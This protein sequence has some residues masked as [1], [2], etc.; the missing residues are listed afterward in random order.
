MAL[1]KAQKIE[2][3]IRFATIHRLAVEAGLAAGNAIRPKTVG[4]YQSDL[5]GNR[6]GP[7]E[8]CS[9]GACG[10]AWVSFPGNTDWGRWAKAKGGAGSH[11]PSGLCYWVRDH[12]QSVD[13]KEAHARAY[14]LVLQNNGIKC[15][16]GSRL[17]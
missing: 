5:Q 3:D 8:W 12:E 2:R 14:A 9:E 13:R 15:H 1:T 7:T 10:F 17:D 11:W 6:L 4:F 16:V